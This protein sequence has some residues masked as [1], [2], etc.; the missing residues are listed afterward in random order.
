MG[1]DDHEERGWERHCWRLLEADGQ[2]VLLQA[3]FGGPP[4]FALEQLAIPESAASPRPTGR[5]RRS[6]LLGEGGHVSSACTR[7]ARLES[8]DRL[9]VHDEQQQI[10]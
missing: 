7:S 6:W 10:L 8:M 9:G 5:R 3:E 1:G 4:K 2:V